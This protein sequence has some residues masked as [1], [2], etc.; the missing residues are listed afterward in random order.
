MSTTGGRWLKCAVAG[1][2]SKGMAILQPDGSLAH[3]TTDASKQAR[4][5]ILYPR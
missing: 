3:L 5:V 4:W 1:D 2:L